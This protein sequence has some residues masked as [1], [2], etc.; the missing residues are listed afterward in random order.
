M[1]FIQNKLDSLHCKPNFC[2]MYRIFFYNRKKKQRKRDVT[3]C[4]GDIK[5]SSS[6]SSYLIQAKTRT[7][8]WDESIVDDCSP[9][10]LIISVR[11]YKMHGDERMG[12]TICYA[13]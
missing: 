5:L 6:Y 10:C 2:N 3:L 7:S 13:Y 4:L 9:K 8:I 12:K 1:R 11:T